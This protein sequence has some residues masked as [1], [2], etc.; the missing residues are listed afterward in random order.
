LPFS[1]NSLVE[2]LPCSVANSL[3]G[4]G[5]LEARSR[6]ISP[7][8][9]I[10]TLLASGA[11]DVGAPATSWDAPAIIILKLLAVVFL[12]LLNGFFVASEFAIVKVRATELDALAARGDV[13]TRLARHVTT[14][15]DTYLAATQLG[16]TLASLGLGWLGKP[17]LAHMIEPLLPL[18]KVTSPVLI[19][20]IAFTLVFG[21]ITVLH[22]VLGE[23]A[24]KS[25]A[26]RKALPTTLWVSPP[27]TLFYLV[28]KPAIWLLN[29]LANWLLK[30]M[31]HLEPVSERELAHSEEELRLILD[32]SAKAAQISRV[33]QEI[34]ANAFEVR[35]RL[36]REV[37]TP[38]GEVVYLDIGLSFDDNF[39]RAK[40]A[41]H[42]RFPLCAEHFDHTIG[43][44]HIKDMLAQ[45]DEPEPSLLA[46]KK[47]L[48]IVPEMLPLE[49]LLK[50]F[51][52]RQAHLAV[53]V[54]EFGG[55]VGIVT[56]QHVIAEVI[57]DMPDEFG[58]ERREF[59]R[60][61][62]DEFLVDGSLAIYAMRDSAGLEWEDKDVTTV[63]GYVV[64]RLGYLPR[65]GEQLRINGY[66]VTVEQADPRRVRQL[67]FQLI[68]NNTYPGGQ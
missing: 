12:V 31:F 28:F 25:I 18:V 5:I 56:L 37:M 34:V 22:I 9:K 39:Q 57:G 61:S 41:R 55:N 66:I 58:R 52:D 43:L 35:R 7:D 33:S 26:I 23:L 36:V 17:F 19:E 20:T 32:E 42:T 3:L 45:L 1:K 63:G 46:I 8:M 16:I 40:A 24:P 49:R 64:H 68:P 59:Q 48:V 15:L 65:A 51:R 44:I 30:S 47:E 50:R 53:V 14:H 13:Q 4:W 62:E 11:E 38:R 67:R 54:D 60:I 29:G 6:A 2:D 27:L 21:T 10:F